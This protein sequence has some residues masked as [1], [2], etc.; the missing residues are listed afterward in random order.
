MTEISRRKQRLARRRKRRLRAASYASA[1]VISGAAFAIV[2]VETP[3]ISTLASAV[4]AGRIVPPGQAGGRFTIQAPT[5][6][7][8][9]IGALSGAEDT[10]SGIPPGD[11]QS[12]IDVSNELADLGFRGPNGWV[13]PASSGRP[14]GGPVDG[15]LTFRGNP[16]RSYYGEG[17]VPTDPQ[18]LWSYPDDG[19]L[20]GPTTLGGG[21]EIWCG[22]GWTGQPAVWE[23]EGRTW[24]AF[25]AFD[26]DV[27]FLDAESGEPLRPPF[28]TDDIIKGSVTVD[29]DGY[30]L[31]Y[32][33]SRDDRLHI[34]AFDRPEPEELWSLAATDVS[35]TL[36]NNDW[37]G[38]PLV[39]DDYLF[40]GGENSQ[41]H[42]V[43][44]NRGYDETGNVTVDPELVFNTPG[45]DTELL[46]AHGDNVSI[47]NSVAVA[48]DVVYFGNSG[49]LIQG[50]DISGLDEGVKP[51]RVFRF[52]A[53][54]DTDATIVIDDEGMLYVGAEYEQASARSVEVGQI[55]KLDPSRPNDPVVWSIPVRDRLPDGVWATAALYRDLLVV[56]THHGRLLGIDR[57]TGEVRWEKQLSGKTWQS[58]VIVDDVLIQGDCS[59]TLHGFDLSDTTIEPA[60][61]WELELGGCIESTPAVWRGVIY[62]ATR[63]GN[64]FAI[65]DPS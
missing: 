45:W 51:E 43:K 41:F 54:D 61:L 10:G 63:G 64:F 9:E 65:G 8:S 37:D 6:S 33:G 1:A 38:S 25:G 30:P 56:P 12:T 5:A 24:L 15:L 19:L 4:E 21:T 7:A 29:P 49:G 35:P 20:C 17:P 28:P 3:R 23:R 18:V 13:D 52:W 47:E 48:G 26:H 50:W 40:E 55:I 57:M 62:V 39:I 2:P 53:G 58:P 27:H 59:G 14:Y 46:G 16:T 22:T 44:L 60:P 34:V 42:I 36:W 11:L 31:L 32:T